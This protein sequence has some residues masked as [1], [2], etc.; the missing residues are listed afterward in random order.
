MHKR[1][2]IKRKDHAANNVVG[3]LVDLMLGKMLNQKYANLGSV[4]VDVHIGNELI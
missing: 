1:L 3:Q 2:G 4:V